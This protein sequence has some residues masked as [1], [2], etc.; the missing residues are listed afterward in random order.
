MFSLRKQIRHKPPFIC[1]I[2]DRK[3]PYY[4]QERHHLI[5]KAK[6]GKHKETINVCIDCG[7]QLHALFSLT[8]LKEVYNTLEALK[9]SEKVNKWVKW[10]SKRNDFGSVCMKLKKGKKKK[11]KRK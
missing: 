4:Y 11:K 8:E 5:P 9:A 1:A 2:C 10:I 7:D 6:K 3:V